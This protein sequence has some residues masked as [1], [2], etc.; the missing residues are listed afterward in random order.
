ML[1]TTR[2]QWMERRQGGSRAGRLLLRALAMCEMRYG[3]DVIAGWR[4]TFHNVDS[5]FI[6]RCSEE[7]YRAY[8]AKRVWEDVDVVATIEEAV[9]DSRRL[10]QCFLSW[11]DPEDRRVSVQLKEQRLRRAIDRPVGPAWSEMRVLE[12]AA[13]ERSVKDFEAVALARGAN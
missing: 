6:T 10:G 2:S 12:W 11:T 3:F 5:D 1:V 9:Q 7:E 13:G 4:R 8:L